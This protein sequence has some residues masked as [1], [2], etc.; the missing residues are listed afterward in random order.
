MHKSVPKVPK[1]LTFGKVSKKIPKNPKFLGGGSDPF[2]TKS[3][4][5]LHFFVENVPKLDS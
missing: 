1:V 5:K 4:L 2:W 3:K